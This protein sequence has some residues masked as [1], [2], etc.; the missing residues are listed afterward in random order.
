MVS[1]VHHALLQDNPGV[2]QEQ[3]TASSDLPGDIYHLNFHL[4]HPD[5]TTIRYDLPSK[6][7]K[8]QPLHLSVTL[9]HYNSRT[10]LR[11]YALCPEDDL[12][13]G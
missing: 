3:G 7:A 1:V 11:H 8:R 9:W 10:I 12:D 2:L 5:C 6:L 13:F 4:S